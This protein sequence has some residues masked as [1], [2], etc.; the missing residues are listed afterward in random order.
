MIKALLIAVFVVP[1]IAMVI[2]FLLA[3]TWMQTKEAIAH[4][5]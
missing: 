1:L 4:D 2:A 3:V 5:A